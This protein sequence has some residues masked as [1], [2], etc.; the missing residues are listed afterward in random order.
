[1][2]YGNDNGKISTRIAGEIIDSAADIDRVGR[3]FVASMPAA[4]SDLDPASGF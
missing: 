4:V 1:V 2:R 3:R